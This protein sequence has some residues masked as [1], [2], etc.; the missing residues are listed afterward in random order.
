MNAAVVD[1]D[2]LECAKV[3]LYAGVC[4]TPAG[5]CVNRG[6]PVI[7]VAVQS[8]MHACSVSDLS[9]AC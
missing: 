8:S 6:G 3:N 1:W 7:E 4:N 9:G 5:L 2:G